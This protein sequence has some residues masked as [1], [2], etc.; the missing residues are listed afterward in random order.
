MLRTGSKAL[1]RQEL[2]VPFGNKSSPFL[3]NAT[4]KH[5]LKSFSYSEVIQELNEN[6]YVDDW[7]SDADSIEEVR[8]KFTEACSILAKAGMILAK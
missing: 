4:I 7:L 1:E 8:E 3:L 5:H 6:L 2:R